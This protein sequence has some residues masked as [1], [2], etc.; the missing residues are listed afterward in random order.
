MENYIVAILPAIQRDL[1]LSRCVRRVED[2]PA[3]VSTLEV[4][5]PDMKVS[6]A[7]DDAVSEASV[8]VSENISIAVFSRR[9]ESLLDCGANNGAAEWEL[10]WANRISLYGTPEEVRR[11]LCDKVVS[12]DS[13]TGETVG[14]LKLRRRSIDSG[15]ASVKMVP[16]EDSIQVICRHQNA[17]GLK[18]VWKSIFHRLDPQYGRQQVEEDMESVS[19]D[20]PETPPPVEEPALPEFRRPEYPEFYAGIELWESENH[21]HQEAA[22]LPGAEEFIGSTGVYPLSLLINEDGRLETADRSYKY[23]WVFRMLT[24]SLKGLELRP[25]NVKRVRGGFMLTASFRGMRYESDLT[26][27]FHDDAVK[28]TMKLGYGPAAQ[29][30]EAA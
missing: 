10:K 29:E 30:E 21:L 14:V 5:W 28:T 6:F 15:H 7:S 18:A 13:Q 16:A 8:E 4:S 11:L 2:E 23:N 22:K 26:N 19:D 24:P 9:M 20:A 25:F 1:L 17:Q 27:R 3:S 12:L